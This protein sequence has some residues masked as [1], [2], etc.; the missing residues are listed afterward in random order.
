MHQEADKDRVVSVVTGN[1]QKHLV[2]GISS[3]PNENQLVSA[4]NDLEWNGAGAFVVKE[5]S[6]IWMPVWPEVTFGITK[7]QVG[8]EA[9]YRQLREAPCRPSRLAQCRIRGA[10]PVVVFPQIGNQ[11]VGIPGIISVK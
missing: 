5:I 11:Q 8:Q 7:R 9:K 4:R 10:Q 1:Q 6:G 2:K 3:V